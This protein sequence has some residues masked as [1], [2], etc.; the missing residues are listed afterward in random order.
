MVGR[1][2][3]VL[4]LRDL[5]ETPGQGGHYGVKPGATSLIPKP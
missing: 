3:V 4:G 1:V 5:L 2:A